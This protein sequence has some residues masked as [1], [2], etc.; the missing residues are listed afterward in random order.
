MSLDKNKFTENS[1]KEKAFAKRVPFQI[2]SVIFFNL[3]FLAP[4]L[5]QF[6]APILNCH[7]CP[8]ASMA[9]PIGTI[10]TFLLAGTF[11]CIAIA[12]LLFTAVFFCKQLCF[13]ICPFGFF[14]DILFKLSKKA[15][16]LPKWTDAGK[17]VALILC[18]IILPILLQKAVFCKMCPAGTL[19]AGIPII[20]K[21]F[22]VDIF[23][24]SEPENYINPLF[25]MIGLGF[26]IKLG[27]LLFFIILSVISRRPF[28]RIMCPAG[29]C[30][31]CLKKFSYRY[32]VSKEHF[33]LPGSDKN[34]KT[35][36]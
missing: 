31:S 23:F 24:R 18:V 17:Y 28:C 26:Y 19:E 12:G 36:V 35:N 6:C 20:A 11:P 2:G 3:P 33:F 13:Y 27:I 25:Q 34:K 1:K 14:Q 7:G 30:F 4:Y 9:C 5:K 22:V 32:V 16:I 29:A 15:V 10:Q 8:L 21:S